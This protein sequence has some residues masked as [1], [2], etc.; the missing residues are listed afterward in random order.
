MHSAEA[1]AH[2]GLFMARSVPA[3]YGP[4]FHMAHVTFAECRALV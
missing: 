4:N 1:L 3:C 2:S